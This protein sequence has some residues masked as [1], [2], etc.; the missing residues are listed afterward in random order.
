MFTKEDRWGNILKLFYNEEYNLCLKESEDF[1]EEL[2]KNPDDIYMWIVKFEVALCLKNIGRIRQAMNCAK[3][4]LQYAITDSQKLQV[5]WVLG[6]CYENINK[7]QSLKYYER[8]I[9]NSENLKLYGFVYTSKFNIAKLHN[10][11]NKMKECI[12]SL[13]DISKN[14][15]MNLSLLNNTYKELFDIYIA[16]NRKREALQIMHKVTDKQ[17]KSYMITTVRQSKVVSIGS[18]RSDTYE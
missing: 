8:A 2:K 14:N 5:F 9:I 3:T 7:Q 11:I 16:N 12:H 18:E 1:F 6:G 10:S 13:E 4:S 17:I 15:E